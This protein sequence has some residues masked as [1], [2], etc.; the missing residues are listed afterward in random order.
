MFWRKCLTRKIVIISI[1]RKIIRGKKF[2]FILRRPLLPIR[3]S[4]YHP[5]TDYLIPGT[6]YRAHHHV[7]NERH[8]EATALVPSRSCPP[9]SVPRHRSIPFS[10]PLFLSRTLD[11]SGRAP[12]RDTS[13]SRTHALSDR[14]LDR[15]AV[16]L[17][18]P[19]PPCRPLSWAS[20]RESS[21]LNST[22]HSLSWWV[23][24]N[25]DPSIPS[26]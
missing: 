7:H 15:V 12:D 6:R 8:P 14:S 9:P 26:G 10:P 25:A 20:L 5:T 11:F 22:S 18:P 4:I 17:P 1:W 24:C 23:S 13:R 2:C 16:L 21:P 19:P 3:F